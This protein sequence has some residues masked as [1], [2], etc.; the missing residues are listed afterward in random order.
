MDVRRSETVGGHDLLSQSVNS[1]DIYWLTC[2]PSPLLEAKMRQVRKGST[3]KKLRKTKQSRKNWRPNPVYPPNVQYWNLESKNGISQ[4]CQQ[5]FY[6]LFW[7][8]FF[9]I[10]NQLLVGPEPVQSAFECINIMHSV[11]FR[12][13]IWPYGIEKLIGSDRHNQIIDLTWKCCYF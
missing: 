10:K 2:C 13:A 8:I 4:Y 1:R 7:L 11:R 6:L 3:A 5:N 12:S 9:V